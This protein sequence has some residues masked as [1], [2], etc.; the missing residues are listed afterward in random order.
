MTS[1]EMTNGDEFNEKRLREEYLQSLSQVAEGQM[2]PGQI[3]EVDNEFVY[4]D[5]GL[6]SEGKIPIEEFEQSPTIGDTVYVIVL[7]RESRRG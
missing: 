6:K 1:I 2:V 3:V 5:V 7:N 4:V